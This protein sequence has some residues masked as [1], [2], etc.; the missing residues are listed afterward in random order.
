M[1]SGIIFRGHL[2]VQKGM[3]ARIEWN[4]GPKRKHQVSPVKAIRPN[5]NKQLKTHPDTIK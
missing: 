4:V 5:N 1:R 3:T 2:R